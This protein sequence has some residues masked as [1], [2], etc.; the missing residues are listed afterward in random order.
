MDGPLGICNGVIILVTGVVSVLA[1]GNR[2]LEEKLIFHPESI[3]AW[4]QYYRLVTSGFLHADWQHLVLN[5]ISLYF[6]GDRVE[7]FLGQGPF[8]LIYFGAIVGGN[9]LSLYVHRH[10][11]YLAYGASG[12]V[13]GIIFA[14]IL[15]FPGV[16]VYL[17]F[18]PLAIPGW[19]YAIAFLL[20]SFWAMKTGRGNV[21]HD[22]HLGGAIVGLLIT[23]ALHPESARYH[24]RLF[25]V[26]LAISLLMLAYLWFN[27]LFLPLAAFRGFLSRPGSHRPDLP[28][29]KQAPLQVDAILE[30]INRNGLESLTAEERALLKEVSGKYRRRSESKKPDSDLVF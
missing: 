28:R 1:F 21:G 16:G 24:W 5:M 15:L 3:L 4:K 12:G 10:H 20:G 19:L 22:A 25:L 14:H 2:A 26:L 9:L 17:F 27:P 30:K 7:L 6:F 23:A 18:I 8:L 11:E 13:C 29:H